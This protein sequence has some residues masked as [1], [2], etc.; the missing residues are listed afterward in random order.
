LA[1][2]EAPNTEAVEAVYREAHGN[3]ADEVVEVKEGS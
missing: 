1:L 3:V 2:F